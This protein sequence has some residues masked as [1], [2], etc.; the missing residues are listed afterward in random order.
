MTLYRYLQSG[1]MYPS[2]SIYSGPAQ[3]L[4]WHSLVTPSDATKYAEVCFCVRPSPVLISRLSCLN[5]PARYAGADNLI[6]QFVVP[7]TVDQAPIMP[8]KQA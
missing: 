3:T 4:Q 5:L 7:D 1:Q 8:P 2:S 6:V